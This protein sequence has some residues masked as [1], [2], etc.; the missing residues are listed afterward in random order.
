[1]IIAVPF[2]CIDCQGVAVRGIVF[3]PDGKS[4]FLLSGLRAGGYEPIAD[5]LQESGGSRAWV[6]EHFAVLNTS[7]SSLQS[8]PLLL[9]RYF[10]FARVEDMYVREQC[11][12]V[13]FDV[14]V[15]PGDFALPLD[16][17]YARSSSRA[18]HGFAHV[19]HH[20][21]LNHIASE[22]RRYSVSGHA[23]LCYVKKADD[24]VRD[25]WT[26]R[27]DGAFQVVPRNKVSAVM[28]LQPPGHRAKG[29]MS[30]SPHSAVREASPLQRGFAFRA[31]LVIELP[32]IQNQQVIGV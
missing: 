24:L 13:G 8:R 32:K 27:D 6:K 16:K 2:S 22:G 20:P 10:A 4:G 26:V 3:C 31:G 29:H 23:A 17:G 7:A 30:L 19:T 21:T 25:D 12:A 5:D 11:V 9:E 1:V 28:L 14:F 18:V 15:G